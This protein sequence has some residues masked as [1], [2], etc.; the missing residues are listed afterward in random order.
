SQHFATLLSESLVS[1]MEANKQHREYLYETL[2][3]YLMLFN[4]EK[5]Q[6]EEVIAWFNF[7]F[8]RQYPGELNKEL[9]ERLLVHTKNLLENDE[10]GFS[11][12][13]TAISAARE[14]LTQMSL[15]ERAYQRMKMQFAKSHVP[16]FRLTDVLGPKGLEQFERASGKPLSQGISGF[17]TYNGFHSIFQIQINRTVKGLMEENWGY[18]DDLKAHEI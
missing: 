11:M 5:Y 13:A 4:P 3:T 12:D 10:K 2:K 17:Y 7:Y 16:S 15:P 9:R 18:W 6:Q 8:E 1:E 14:V